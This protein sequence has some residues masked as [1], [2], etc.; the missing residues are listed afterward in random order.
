MIW[1]SLLSKAIK[2]SYNRKP[3]ASRCTFLD[4]VLI[5]VCALL[6]FDKVCLT[7]VQ[8]CLAVAAASV[9][10]MLHVFAQTREDDVWHWPQ[11]DP[12]C[13]VT[14]SLR[15]CSGDGDV[16]PAKELHAQSRGRIL[17]CL[18]RS[19]RNWPRVSNEAPPKLQLH[20]KPKSVSGIWEVI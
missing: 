19:S 5:H 16:S 17:L 8:C 10:P 4:R 9:S 6:V 11:Y 12:N 1:S 15:L 13:V 18:C 2:S 14:V 3:K 7:C 20:S